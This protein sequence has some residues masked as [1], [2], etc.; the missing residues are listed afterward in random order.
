MSILLKSV[1]PQGIERTSVAVAIAKEPQNG[2]VVMGGDKPLSTAAVLGGQEKYLARLFD[3]FNSEA[4]QCNQSHLRLELTEGVVILGQVKRQ[5]LDKLKI[6]VK[7]TVAGYKG[8]PYSYW[9]FAGYLK[10]GGS[11]FT[12]T[13]ATYDPARCEKELRGIAYQ[14]LLAKAREMGGVK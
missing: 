14:A 13:T 2:D 11:L 6:K 5:P 12:P 1:A 8:Q 7:Q 10:H 4:K 3:L 9:E